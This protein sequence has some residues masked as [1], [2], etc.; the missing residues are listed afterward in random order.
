MAKKKIYIDPSKRGTFTAEAKKRGMG[1]QEF[2]SKVMSN[3]DRYSSSMVKQANFA[4]NAANWNQDGGNMNAVSLM[5][6][7]DDSH[8]RN[9]ESL[10]IYSPDGLIDMSNVG[11]PIVANG[12]VLD[13]YSGIN[14]V[15]PTKS[16]YV[17]ETPL[18]TFEN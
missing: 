3:K 9:E 15:P 14:Q 1:V 7:R 12:Q 13:P 4:R 18:E 5:G 16:G 10:N 17:R 11:M 8:F 6:Y 2:A